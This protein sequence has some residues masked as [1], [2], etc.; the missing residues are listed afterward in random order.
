MISLLLS[1]V[2]SSLIFILFKLLKRTNIALFPV[3]V[4][5]YITASI[6]GLVFSNINFSINY[7]VNLNW[8]P[9]SVFLGFLFVLTFFLIGFSSQKLGLMITSISTKMSVVLPILFSIYYYSENVYFSKVL[10]I[11]FALLALFFSSFKGRVNKNMDKIYLFLPFLLFFGAG[12]IDTTVKYSQFEY[13]KNVDVTA[14]SA[15]TFVF[16]VITSLIILSF[17][18]YSFKYLLEKQTVI[19]GFFLG[20]VNF[21]SLYFIILALN[22]KVFDSSIIFAIVS[23]GTIIISV[24]TGLV[25]FKERIKVINWI[26]VV[27]SIVAIVVLS[28]NW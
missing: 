21:A 9:I 1:I 8:L 7:I 3:I 23:T 15:I 19:W 13:L 17:S 12:I 2:S 11:I 16:S 26:G 14:F 28:S 22:S 4:I 25:F 10:G 20:L 27:L 6:F 5:N 24:L 18:K